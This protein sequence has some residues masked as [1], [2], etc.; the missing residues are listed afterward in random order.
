MKRYLTAKEAAEILGISS[1]T[2]YAYVSRGLIRS[3]ATSEKSRERRYFAQDVQ[4]LVDRKAQRRD[5]SLAAQDALDWGTPILESALTLITEG[6]LFYR[7]QAVA[8][9]A[10]TRT[11]EEVAALLWVDRM[12]V[13]MFSTA[14]DHLLPASAIL[15]AADSDLTKMQ[16]ALILAGAHDLAAYSL[17]PGSVILSGARILKLMTYALT[18][19]SEQSIAVA[20]GSAW[21]TDSTHLINAAL[22]LC[23]DHE[24]NAS[25]FTTR[26]IASTEAT[27]YAVVIGG[28]SALQGVKHG[29]I[30]LRVASFLRDVDQ[31]ESVRM[32]L[33][34]W[35]Q[36]GDP[37]PGFGHPLYPQGDPR[38]RVLFD[39]LQDSYPEDQSL[40]HCVEVMR[41]VQGVIGEAPTIDFALVVLTRVLKLPPDSGLTLFALGRTAGWIAHTIEQYATRQLI[42]PR[43]KYVGRLP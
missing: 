4:A 43:A 41:E 33:R 18:L 29:G 27:P 11:F 2:L 3:E 10:Q 19:E 1:T 12:D 40:R 28:L 21:G 39:M 25:S 15:G 13:E 30:T 37:I 42:R 14:I 17:A 7:G 9:L 34:D 16:L 36:R 22:I 35:L 24:L 6:A 32:V 23:A 5:P 8:T 20:L 31:A 38:A 26:V